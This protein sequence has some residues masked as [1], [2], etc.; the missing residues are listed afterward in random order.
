MF[1][2]IFQRSE[3]ERGKFGKCQ[4]FRI[5]NQCVKGQSFHMTLYI[6]QVEHEEFTGVDRTKFGVTP[7]QL[8]LYNVVKWV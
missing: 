8:Q 1:M 7:L 2:N 6:V 5:R 3:N 4:G